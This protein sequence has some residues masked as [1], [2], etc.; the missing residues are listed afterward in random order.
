MKQYQIK[1]DS[2]LCQNITG[3]SLMKRQD[4]NLTPQGAQGDVFTILQ[5]T[6]VTLSPMWLMEH[7][8]ELKREV[9]FIIFDKPSACLKGV[10]T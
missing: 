9:L 1:L 10:N 6:G 2:E 4:W 8:M 5:W 3:L 7:K